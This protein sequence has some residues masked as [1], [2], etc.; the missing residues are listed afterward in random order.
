[1]NFRERES[2]FLEEIKFDFKDSVNITVGVDN[3]FFKNFRIDFSVTIG[4]KPLELVKLRNRGNFTTRRDVN[5]YFV[6]SS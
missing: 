3:N 4:I 6:I 2:M 5:F 1:M